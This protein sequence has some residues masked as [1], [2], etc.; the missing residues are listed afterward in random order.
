MSM[1]QSSLG[2]AGSVVLLLASS[3]LW[4]IGNAGCSS[5]GSGGSGQSSTA[6]AGGSGDYGA[7]EWSRGSRRSTP[8]PAPVETTAPSPL[9]AAPEEDVLDSAG[10]SSSTPPPPTEPTSEVTSSAA[11]AAAETGAPS[12]PREVA[13]VTTEATPEATTPAVTEPPATAGAATDMSAAVATGEVAAPSEPAPTPS[14]APAT[15]PVIAP[16]PATPAATAPDVPSTVPPSGTPPTGA[17]ASALATEI[18]RKAT[19]SADPSI[20]AN[21]IESLLASPA[22][23]AEVLPTGLADQNRGVR[24]VSAMCVGRANLSELAPFVEPLLK[25]PSPSVQAAAIYALSKC[26]RPVD[27]TP[28]AAMLQS[29]DPEV[30]ANAFVVLGELGNKS[31]IPMIRAALGQGMRRVHPVRVRIV[32][33]QGAEALVRLGSEDDVEGIRAA[34]FA[35]GEQGELSILAC[36]ILARV[37]DQSAAPMM[38]RLVDASGTSAR[39]PEIRLA[40]AQ[41]LAELKVSARS[42]LGAL[43]AQF[44][45]SP[46]HFLRVQ[47]AILLGRVGGPGSVQ[48]LSALLSD[49]DDSVRIAAAA[50]LLRLASESRGWAPASR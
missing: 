35:P 5:G 45:S 11:V 12:E 4:L 20:R 25:D 33:L 23:L 28:L 50:G 32:E 1:L 36:Q 39:P 6:S 7:D 41:S 21:A 48:I 30:R 47:A 24:F 40:A 13:T 17:S 18:L 15:E 49:P 42:N 22:V 2:R 10:V 3:S 31:A 44:A 16:V 38:E 14:V 27:P 34:L 46:D 37:G 26:G 43:G 29:D 9:A 19:R 8:A